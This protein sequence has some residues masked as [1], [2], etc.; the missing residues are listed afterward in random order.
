MADSNDGNST[1]CNN[2]N[3]AD[4][5]DPQSVPVDTDWLELELLGGNGIE[6][7]LNLR[8]RPSKDIDVEASITKGSSSDPF[9]ADVFLTTAKGD[10]PDGTGEFVIHATPEDSKKFRQLAKAAT[11]GADYLETS[12]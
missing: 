5:P 8:L 2:D 11:Q 4:G 3:S 6:R 7:Y 9:S 1:D 10:D 12:P